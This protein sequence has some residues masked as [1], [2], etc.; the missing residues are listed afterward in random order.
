MLRGCG[1][2]ITSLSQQHIR[3]IFSSLVRPRERPSKSK[4]REGS[5]VALAS[6]ARPGPAKKGAAGR[7]ELAASKATEDVSIAITG[8][9]LATPTPIRKRG[10][11]PKTSLLKDSEGCETKPRRQSRTPEAEAS[12]EQKSATKATT[13]RHRI[14]ERLVVPPRL[15][16]PSSLNHHDL[17]SFLAHASRVGLSEST[18]TYK[19]T[20]YE[21]TVAK[22]LSTLNF[23]LHRTGRSNDLGIDLIGHWVLP[24]QPS[25]QGALRVLI[26]CKAVQPTPS[27]VREL[28]GAYVGAPAGWRGD[29]VLA[30]LVASK[31]ATKGV[32]AALQRSRWPMGVLQ[33]TREG[34][35]KQF[36]WNA[37][38]AE[39]GLEGLGVTVRYHGDASVGKDAPGWTDGSI[40]LTW[41][42][43]LAQIPT[44]LPP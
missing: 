25:T 10:R 29:G 44:R 41:L 18:N 43:R 38:A 15:L 8:E 23:A 24:S 12:F 16:P 36:L 9:D 42:G 4:T 22:T 31:E 35:V 7:V 19:G 17:P 6:D 32:R 2:L 34:Q 26:Q 11:P 1:R 28:E 27:M 13:S 5:Q 33:V 40:A 37:M 21:Y 30:L 39:A 20:H 14:K 3:S